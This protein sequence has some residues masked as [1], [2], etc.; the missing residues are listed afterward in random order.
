MN[1]LE[2][3]S[4]IKTKS[5]FVDFV[6]SLVKDLRNNSEEWPNNSLSDYLESMASWT[7]DMEGYYINNN[8]PVPTNVDWRIFANILIAAKIYE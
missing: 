3:S 8:M 6:N 2:E 1:T 7:E 4:L 5:D